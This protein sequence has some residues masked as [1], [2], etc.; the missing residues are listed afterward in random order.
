MDNQQQP[1][2]WDELA[3]ELGAEAPPEPVNLPKPT[4]S[5][6]SVREEPRRKT[7]APAPSPKPS[8]PSWDSLAADLGL[9]V[10]PPPPPAPPTPSHAPVDVPPPPREAV[11]RR[12]DDRPPRRPRPPR[13]EESADAQDRPARPPRPQRD[14]A[15]RR[16]REQRP[17][18]GR[19]ETSRRDRQESPRRGREQQPPR[20]E[21]EELTQRTPEQPPP[22]SPVAPEPEI[23]AKQ[24]P[25]LGVSLWHKIFGSPDEQAERIAE[26]SGPH[27]ADHPP[28]SRHA[29]EDRPGRRHEEPPSDRPAEPIAE[30]SETWREESVEIEFVD[31]A[32]TEDLA[33]RPTDENGE[34]RPRRRRRGRGR[35]RGRRP[36]GEHRE[37]GS[38]GRATDR[39]EAETDGRDAPREPRESRSQREPRTR[40]GRSGRSRRE[41]PRKQ[42]ILKDDLDDGLEEIVLDDDD[43]DMDLG[44]DGEDAGD[45]TTG[46]VPAGHRSIPSWDEAIGIIVDTNLSTRTDR[47]RSSS[48]QTRG[49]GPARG[50]SRGGRRRKKS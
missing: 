6:E 24:P 28:E 46:R 40:G 31:T 17:R 27:G 50:R 38:E 33:T 25:S 15:P 18:R 45:A 35:G 32:D 11:S 21:R 43:T 4:S 5:A 22:P 49:S 36:D 39:T 3:R 29:R 7:V 47:R 23:E 34:P 10:P 19:E 12:E 30:V 20:R 9:E 41:A 13:R 37:Q 42:D 44:M 8:P 16:E 2:K 1:S 48:P 14:E 26:G